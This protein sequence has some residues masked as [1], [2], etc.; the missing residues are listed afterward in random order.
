MLKFPLLQLMQCLFQV[1]TEDTAS[2]QLSQQVSTID[3]K[4]K[5]LTGEI[6]RLEEQATA[7]A[8]VQVQILLHH[9]MAIACI[10]PAVISHI[11]CVPEWSRL[12]TSLVK[13]TTSCCII[14]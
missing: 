2:Q 3:T 6:D 13:T 7:A 10:A 1:A 9:S 8:H 11:I 14:S 12:L 5:I 4:L